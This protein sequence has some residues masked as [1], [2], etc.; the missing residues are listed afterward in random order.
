MAL[1]FVGTFAANAQCW[2][3]G[4]MSFWQGKSET[5]FSIAPEIGYSFYDNPISLAAAFGYNYYSYEDDLG[6]DHT[7]DAFVV[8]PYIR[9][10]CYHASI[11]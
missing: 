6:D 4:N 1:A 3:G 5:K 11:F 2:M 7:T 9:F 10:L 8:S